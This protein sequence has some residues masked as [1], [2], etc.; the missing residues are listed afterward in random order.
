MA[1]P[2]EMDERISTL[3]ESITKLEEELDPLLSTPWEQLTGSGPMPHA[4]ALP[5]GV[6]PR[7]LRAACFRVLP[8]RAPLLTPPL[9]PLSCVRLCWASQEAGA[10]GESKA[11]PHDRLRGRLAL[12]H[13]LE[14]PGRREQCTSLSPPW[15][16]TFYLCSPPLNSIFPSSPLP[17]TA[18]KRPWHATVTLI[19]C[20][21]QGAATEEHPVT[22][23]LARIKTYMGKLKQLGEGAAKDQQRLKVRCFRWPRAATR[24][25]M[26]PHA[27]VPPPRYPPPAACRRWH[28]CSR[29]LSLVGKNR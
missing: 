23:E 22:E 24:P 2:A 12:L 28:A 16:L 19:Q 4:T 11:Q 25:G 5:R 17:H 26:P 9:P 10:N 27:R 13:V 20:R 7:T 15:R 8:R 29:T 1:L 3:E 14:D 6:P 21:L 18:S